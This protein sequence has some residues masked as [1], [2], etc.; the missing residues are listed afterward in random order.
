MLVD[1]LAEYA[2]RD[3]ARELPQRGHPPRQARVGGLVLGPS[4]WYQN[5]AGN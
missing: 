2:R 1:A 5:F 4:S 3:S